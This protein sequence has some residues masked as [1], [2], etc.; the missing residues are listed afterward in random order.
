VNT[1]QKLTPVSALPKCC[2]A[3]ALHADETVEEPP[4]VE[5]DHI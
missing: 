1:D 4:F 3:D 5:R 2:D